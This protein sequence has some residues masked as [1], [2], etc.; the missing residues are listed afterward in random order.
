MRNRNV[1]EDCS[2]FIRASDD[3]IAYLSLLL[4]PAFFCASN[5]IAADVCWSKVETQWLKNK[6]AVQYLLHKQLNT[7]SAI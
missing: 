7:V 2:D 6:V 5:V 1:K 4:V 3:A